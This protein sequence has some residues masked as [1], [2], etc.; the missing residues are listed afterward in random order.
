MLSESEKRPFVD[1]AERLRIQHKK[2]HPDYKYQPRR[3]KNVKPGQSDSDSGAELAHMYKAEPG[4]GGLGGLT[5][6]HH[7]A[8]HAGRSSNSINA[9]LN[10]RFGPLGIVCCHDFTPEGLSVCVIARVLA[11]GQPHGPP[12]PPTTPKTDLHHGAK[13]DLK[14]EGRR[15]MDSGR[16]NIDFSNVDISELSTDV[17]SNMETFDVHEFDQY[18]PLNGHTPGSSGLPSDQPPPPVGSYAS[19]YAHAGVNGSAWSRKGAMSSSSPSSGEVG[20]HRLHIKTEQLSPS[21]YSEHSH[22][23]PPH[24]D[25]GSYSS[26]A[27]VP[28]APSAS[29]VPFSGSPCDYSELQSSNYYNPYSSYSS[30]LYQYP[31]FHSSRRPYGS[32]ILNSLSMAPAHSPTGSGWD[33]PVYTTLSRP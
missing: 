24:S 27:C 10:V 18:L 9:P 20:Q 7:H 19:S 15:L 3:R 26:P 23:S 14:H 30:S 21:H 12:T 25:Y 28:S 17:I 13:Q 2:D 8:E 33:Q 16:Q 5:D 1:E 22:R 29:S 4:M 31:Y 32:P 6:G 11:T